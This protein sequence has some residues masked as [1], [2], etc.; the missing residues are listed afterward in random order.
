[1]TEPLRKPTEQNLSYMKRIRDLVEH[2]CVQGARRLV[3]EAIRRGVQDEDILQW[4]R[5]L[6]SPKVL[7]FT[8]ELEPDRTPEFDWLRAHGKEYLGQWV[9]L[10]EDG[11]LAH[12]VHLAEVEAAVKTMTLNRFPLLYYIQAEHV[13]IGISS[14]YKVLELRPIH[15]HGDQCGASQ[16][17]GPP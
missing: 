15:G 17:P 4:Q 9:A 5:V 3:A 10:A 12:S 2:D 16:A 11:L 1:M 8:D 14:D 6:A 13:Y 7:E